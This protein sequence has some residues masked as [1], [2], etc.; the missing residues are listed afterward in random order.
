MSASTI[1]PTFLL[2]I[3]SDSCF[4]AVWHPLLGLNPFMHSKNFDSYIASI[5]FFNASC[6]ILS[7]YIAIPN[8]LVFPFA[9]GIFT[10]L[11]GAGINDL[12]FSLFAKSLMLFSKFSAYSFFVT[13]SIPVALLPSNSLWHIISISS[14]I[15]WYIDGTFL[16]D[17]PLI[18]PLFFIISFSLF[19]ILFPK[20]TSYPCV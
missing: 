19:H 4:I 2:S 20:L 13:L 8:G 17:Y 3:L 5:I 14:F 11:A 6:T 1:Y 16:L 12:F 18:F 15:K 10:L 9:L 7:S